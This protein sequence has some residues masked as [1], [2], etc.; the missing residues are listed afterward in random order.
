LSAAVRSLEDA[1][2]PQARH[3]AECL[4]AAVLGT[5]RGGVY[6]RR[7][8]PMSAGQTTRYRSWVERRRARVPLQH[9]FGEQEF[10][11]HGFKVDSRV[12]I[13]RPETELLVEAA[14]EPGLRRGARVVDLG[15]G[16]GCIAISLAIARPDLSVEALD[17]SP[18][19]LEL[20]RDNARRLGVERRV[21]FIE[22]DLADPP[23]S[24]ARSIDLVVSNPPYVS[25]SEWARL[26]P[27]VRDHDPRE[28]LVAGP[29]G[30]ECY[31]ALSPVVRGLLNRGGRLLL[32]LGFGQAESVR[33]IIQQV[34]FERV[35]IRPDMQQIPRILSAFTPS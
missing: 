17:R 12:L 21:R 25:E 11:G 1:G 14:L 5:D 34:G 2:V 4:L 31:R 18:A 6:V 10:F 35:T 16:S 23:E 24:W 19:A 20:A 32:E 28:A 3:D 33:S 9:L 8:D 15:T 13:P 30:D 22:R 26:E 29:A 27:E 7:R